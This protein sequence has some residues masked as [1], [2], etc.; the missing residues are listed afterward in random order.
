MEEY[1]VVKTFKMDFRRKRGNGKDYSDTL[2]VEKGQILEEVDGVDL[3]FRIKGTKIGLRL[4]PWT[5]D[6]CLDKI[7]T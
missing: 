2:T 6:A 7:S 5:V 3:F 1:K 4:S